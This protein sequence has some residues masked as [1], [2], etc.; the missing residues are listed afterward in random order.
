M[1]TSILLQISN[2]YSSYITHSHVYFYYIIT[3]NTFLIL[4]KYEIHIRSALGQTITSTDI[5]SYNELTSKHAQKKSDVS[6][7]LE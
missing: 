7:V 2:K 1:S 5:M 3:T 4:C 6:G